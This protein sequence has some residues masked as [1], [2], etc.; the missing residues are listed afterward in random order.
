MGTNGPLGQSQLAGDLGVGVPG[1]NEAQE[2][3]M[4]GSELGNG[5]ASTFRIE[6]GLVEMGTQ[7]REEG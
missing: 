7:Q 4:P 2:I 1:G 3:P 5:A 6:I